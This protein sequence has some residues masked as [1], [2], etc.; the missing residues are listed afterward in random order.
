MGIERERFHPGERKLHTGDDIGAENNRQT[1][2][3]GKYAA[4]GSEIPEAR[5]LGEGV[6]CH[7]GE[8][9]VLLVFRWSN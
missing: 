6:S 4:R 7:S 9:I 3:V 1:G 2:I 5:L 8:S